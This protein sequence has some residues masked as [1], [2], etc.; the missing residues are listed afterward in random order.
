[1]LS[2]RSLVVL[3]AALIAGVAFTAH[4]AS[5][6]LATAISYPEALAR[7]HG[8]PVDPKRL[9]AFVDQFATLVALSQSEREALYAER[10]YFSDALLTTESRAALLDHLDT[11]HANSSDTQL[12]VLREVVSGPDVYLVWSMTATFTPVYQSVSSESVGI[13]HLRFN[14]AGQVVLQHDFWDTANGF[15][16]H[17]PVLGALVRAIGKRF[18]YDQ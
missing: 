8:S 17:I 5:S 11:V 2:A 10:L 13:T 6:P 4:M 9:R 15:Y 16:Q 14:A 3:V 7:Y 1:M 12:T 18:D